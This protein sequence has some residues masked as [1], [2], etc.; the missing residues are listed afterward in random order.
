MN[1]GDEMSEPVRVAL[2][3]LTRQLMEAYHV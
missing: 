2:E 3:V 1:L